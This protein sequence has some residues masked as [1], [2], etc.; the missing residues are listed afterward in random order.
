MKR[1]LILF[2][3]LFFTIAVFGQPAG[4][5][6]KRV[7]F[8]INAQIFPT[9]NGPSANFKRIPID[10][11]ENNPAG[12]DGFDISW[13]AGAKLGFALSRKVQLTL[14]GDYLRTAMQFDA[15]R[16]NSSG[17]FSAVFQLSGI[18]AEVGVRLFTLDNGYLAPWGQYWGM[19]LKGTMISGT[20]D[21][22]RTELDPI[23]YSFQGIDDLDRLVM[24]F[25]LE[26]GYNYIFKDKFFINLAGQVN[27]PLEVLKFID[28][29]D[30]LLGDNQQRYEVS[31]VN[32]LS[33][34]SLLT[35]NFGIGILL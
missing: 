25:G 7:T 14:G 19:N 15:F 16:N 13:R 24:T 31:V 12:E 27:I 4:Y 8:D 1:K 23:F 18:A 2:A 32:R 9:L 22:E 26:Y 10:I 28:E 30:L 21:E 11:P 17:S 3:S 5:L 29:E 35:W 6:G 34:H 20:W 33:Y